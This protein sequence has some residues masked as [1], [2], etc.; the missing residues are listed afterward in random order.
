MIALV[1]L[2]RRTTRYENGNRT[3]HCARYFGLGKGV[4]ALNLRSLLF[5]ALFLFACGAAFRRPIYGL[6]AYVATLYIHPPSRW[7]GQGWMEDIRWALV[8][9]GITLLAVLVR[10]RTRDTVSLRQFPITW[11]FVFFVLWLAVQLLWS[12]SF[13]LQWELFT[14]YLKF[15]VVIYLIYYCI[16][17]EKDLQLFL[18]SNVLGCFFLGWLAFTEYT[19]GRFEGFGGPG[20][21]EANAAANQLAVGA[22]IAG[23]MF[24][25]GRLLVKVV[26]VG[27]AP[28]IV[29]GLVTTASRSGFLGIAVGG[30]IFNMFAPKF[31]KKKVAIA[32]LL[33]VVLL[34]AV[35]NPIYWARMA[36]IKVSGQEIEGMDTGGGRRALLTAQ[37]E[38]FQDHPLGCGHR[39]TNLLSQRYVDDRYLIGEG[40]ERGLSSHNTFLSL[41]VEQGA[42]GALFYVG[43]LGWSWSIVR[44]LKRSVV[45]RQ[46][47][48]PLLLPGVVAALSAILVGDLFVDYVKHEARIWLIALL[49]VMWRLSQQLPPVDSEL[50]TQVTPIR[51]G[52]GS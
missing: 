50:R 23:S 11:M 33:G 8:A 25:A 39:C 14:L 24:L 5:V 20:L 3:F 46:D 10:R 28:F 6:L 52:S 9:A 1:F 17:T 32:S 26:V 49:M 41:L 47:S 36:S 2:K 12:I 45:G 37:F 18:L 35:T 22:L 19:T 21:G 42:V 7:W 27:A 13:D 15:G 38:M 44:K 31:A 34:L 29:N 16:E 40:P 43:M 30:L 48:L 4:A 51:S